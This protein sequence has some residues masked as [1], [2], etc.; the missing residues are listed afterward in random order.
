MPDPVRVA[1]W[2]HCDFLLLW[3]GQAV[4]QVGSQVTVLALPLVAIVVLHATTFEVGLLSAAT[5]GAYLLIALPAGVVA[6][7]VA[8]RSLMLASDAAQVV[9]IGS[10]PLAYA[11]GVLTLGQLYL[12]ALV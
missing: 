8:K 4:S 3:A 9:V 11:A 1:L 5:T 2:R 7:R 6:D 12:V 10:V